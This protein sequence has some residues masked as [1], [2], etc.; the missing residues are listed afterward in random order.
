M[1][2]DQ[3]LYSCVASAGGCGGGFNG[4]ESLLQVLTRFHPEK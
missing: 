3:A 4:E 2:D 1:G